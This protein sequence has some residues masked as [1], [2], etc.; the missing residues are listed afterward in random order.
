MTSAT[1]TAGRLRQFGAAW[2][3]A[4]LDALMGFVTDD[5]TYL[6]SVGP[7]PG[8]TYR[9]RE[10]VRRGF[11]AMLAYDRGRERHAGTVVV[12]GDTGFAEWSF[13]ETTTD[14]GG[15]LIRGCDLFQFRD[16]QIS[17][18]DAYRK[19]LGTVPDAGAAQ[20]EDEVTN[21]STAMAGG[22]PVTAVPAAP[23]GEARNHFEQR[24]AHETDP[25]DVWKAIQTGTVDF[26]LV[27]CRP[28]ASYDKA[29]LPG[30][31][32]LPVSEMDPVH[33]AALPQGLLVTYCW[34]PSCNAA[35]KGAYRL[36]A[37]GCQVKELIGGLEYW[38]REGHPVEGR[39][40][41]ARGQGQPSD[42]GLVS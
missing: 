33:V 18:K 5:C 36:A 42:W 28:R 34:G 24:L 37:L 29:H 17:K 8:T 23:A 26:A 12:A 2:A 9:G 7:E 1:M 21:A 38:I 40:P 4:D 11:A 39:R 31:V 6:A 27:D 32:S 16:G 14:G 30:A 15:R 41:V 13:T 35:T 22:S 25:A 19:L 3:R 20:K 10:E